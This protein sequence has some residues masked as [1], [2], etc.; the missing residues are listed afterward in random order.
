[1]T[2]TERPAVGVPHSG[3][4][5]VH[6]ADTVVTAAFPGAISIFLYS[7]LDIAGS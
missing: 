6:L 3:I 4:S 7:A 2:A 5:P 1:M